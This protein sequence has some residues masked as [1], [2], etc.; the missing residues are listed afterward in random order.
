[1]ARVA[2]DPDGGEHGYDY[3]EAIVQTRPRRRRILDYSFVAQDGAVARY[4]V[5]RPG[6]STAAPGSSGARPTRARAGS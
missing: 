3:W 5:R 2:T 6:A 1:M 4:P